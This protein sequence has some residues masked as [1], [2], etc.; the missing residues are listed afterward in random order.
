M[1]QKDGDCEK[2]EQVKILL[3]SL[4]EPSS[5]TGMYKILFPR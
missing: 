3:S 2:Y 4:F 1:R 5:L